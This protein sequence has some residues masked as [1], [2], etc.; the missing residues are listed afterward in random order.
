MWWFM[1]SEWFDY[2]MRRVACPP[3]RENHSPCRMARNSD[4]CREVI[5]LAISTAEQ[6]ASDANF[7]PFTVIARSN[8]GAAPVVTKNERHTQ[9][10]PNTHAHTPYMSWLPHIT[11][12]NEA[13]PN[14]LLW[15][16]Y[17]YTHLPE[18]VGDSGDEGCDDCCC[19]ESSLASRGSAPRNE[20][21]VT[22]RPLPAKNCKYLH[23]RVQTQGGKH[24]EFSKKNKLKKVLTK[25]WFLTLPN[26][27]PL[28]ALLRI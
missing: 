13:W 24:S 12:S 9:L 14:K 23:T 20:R 10:T 21:S 17:T 15:L 4:I 25:G 16:S 26:A 18:R 28:F 2:L 7:T 8:G 11:L 19:W 1:L 6:S 5:C 27:F 22:D 3:V